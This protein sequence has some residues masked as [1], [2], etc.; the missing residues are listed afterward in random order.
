MRPSSYLRH[1]LLIAGL[2]VCSAASAISGSASINNVHVQLFDL[3]PLDGV[4]PSLTLRDENTIVQTFVFS[5]AVQ[6]PV[7]A[8]GFDSLFLIGQSVGPVPISIPGN[9]A[10][11]QAFGGSVFNLSSPG[12]SG[13]VSASSDNFNRSDATAYSFARAVI[14]PH[15]LV[16]ITAEVGPLTVSSSTLGETGDAQVMVGVDALDGSAHASGQAFLRFYNPQSQTRVLPS[17]ISA[18]MTNLSAT[19]LDAQISF[20]AAV[21]VVGVPVP[22]P[23]SATLLLAG[24]AMIGFGALRRQRG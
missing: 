4:A 7:L 24:L 5:D 12:W 23:Q 6:D 10:S 17:T 13:T 9:S 8:Q 15:T 19:G 2:L 16:V 11:A 21:N 22:E 3:D 14:S 18:S 1:S 20:S